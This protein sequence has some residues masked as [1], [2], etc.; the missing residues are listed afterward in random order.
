MKFCG[1]ITKIQFSSPFY[2]LSNTYL[3]SKKITGYSPVIF[4]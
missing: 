1:E 4:I 3:V 2:I